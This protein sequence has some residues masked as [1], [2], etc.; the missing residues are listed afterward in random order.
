[1]EQTQKRNIGNR[2]PSLV[3]SALI[4]GGIGLAVIII[5]AL[6]SPLLLLNMGDPN[7]MITP[8]AAVCVFIGGATGSVI[9]ARLCGESFAVSGLISASVMLLP[10]LLVSFL[11]PGERN[12][13]LSA[14]MSAVLLASSL[15]SSFAASRIS[16]NRKKN[17]KKLMKRR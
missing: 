17:M 9:A 12:V 15:L 10:I 7:S 3:V 8:V 13:V 4:G 6:I 5:T 1:M 14:A 11:I 2:E 16:S